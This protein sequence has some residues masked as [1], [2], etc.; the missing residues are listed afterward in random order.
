[1]D[2]KNLERYEW[3]GGQLLAFSGL[4]GPTDFY[5]GITARTSFGIPGLDFKFPAEGKVTFPE[6]QRSLISGDFFELQTVEGPV[7]GAFIDAWHLLIEGPCEVQFSQSGAI[8]ILWQD[9]KAKEGQMDGSLTQRKRILIGAATHFAPAWIDL[10]LQQILSRRQRWLLEQDLPQDLSDSSRRTLG[11]ALSILKT[12]VYTPEGQIQHC[13]T[14]PDRW[15]HRGMWLWDSVF[16]AIGWRHLQPDLARDM[17]SAVLDIQ[18]EDGFIAHHS[19]PLLKTSITQPPVLALGVQLIQEVQPNVAWLE[20]IYPRLSA[21]LNWDLIHRDSSGD[22]L[23]E[24]VIE[25]DENNRSGE[26]GMD[27]S[28]RFDTVTWLDAVDFNAFLAREY[29]LMAGFAQTLGYMEEAAGWHTR[30][31]ALCALINQRLWSE[32]VGFYLDYDVEQDVQ[33]PV[34]AS[35]GFLPL[36]CGAASPEQAKILAAHLIDPEM[37]STPLRVASI[38]AGD[39]AHYAKDMWRGPVW[40]NVNWLIASGLAR[41]GLDELAEA[42]QRETVDVIEREYGRYGTLFEFYDDRDE[43]DPPKLLRKGRCA[44]EISPYHQ[45]FH[46]YGWTAS[47]YVDWMFTRRW[48]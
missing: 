1:M 17:I 46:D 30:H 22:G 47:L 11:K 31:Q 20:T 15:P 36:I 5:E 34:I 29:E 23:V 2:L 4:D 40:V 16:H 8:Q 19:T 26:S 14:T 21:Y 35:S 43:L 33:S 44:P 27:N 9:E 32:E 39:Q 12:Q 18:A 38:A 48:S 42:L 28:P 10:D 25:A 7:R 37:F 3:Y 13:W 41:Y 45:V 24:W 6:T